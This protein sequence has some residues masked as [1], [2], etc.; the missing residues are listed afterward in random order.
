MSGVLV[1][2]LEAKLLFW[3]FNLLFQIK[4]KI[5]AKKG[6]I[7]TWQTENLQLW[8]DWDYVETKFPWFW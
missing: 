1:R 4:C 2:W 5:K 3:L 6:G 7:K 8:V